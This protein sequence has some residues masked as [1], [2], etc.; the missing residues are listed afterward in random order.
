MRDVCKEGCDFPLNDVGGAGGPETWVGAGSLEKCCPSI[1]TLA[2]AASAGLISDP[3][4]ECI[5]HGVREFVAV[6]I[7]E[8][9]IAR[10]AFAASAAVGVAGAAIAVLAAALAGF[11]AAILGGDSRS[12]DSD[13][14]N[15]G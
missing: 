10:A 11:A 4:E 7:P 8:G 3:I 5:G 14:E 15:C 12:E 13:Y 6:A 2:R 1:E 9:G